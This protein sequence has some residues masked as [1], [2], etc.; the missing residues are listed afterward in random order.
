MKK[1]VE[2]LTAADNEEQG[3]QCDVISLQEVGF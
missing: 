3:A 1:I 2:A